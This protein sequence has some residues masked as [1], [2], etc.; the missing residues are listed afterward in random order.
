MV[1]GKAKCLARVKFLTDKN[2]CTATHS[3]CLCDHPYVQTTQTRFRCNVY[4]I[5]FTYYCCVLCEC[6]HFCWKGTMMQM[7][8]KPKRL[9]RTNGR[10]IKNKWTNAH[11]HVPSRFHGVQ[12]T[13]VCLWAILFVSSSCKHYINI[14]LFFPSMSLPSSVDT[15]KSG[16][17][18][19]HRGEIFALK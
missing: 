12:C 13:Y 3:Y 10:K 16:W 1:N 15:A 2:R 7:A 6:V 8:R 14:V 18:C 4:W 11:A 17:H 19:K 5:A 9:H